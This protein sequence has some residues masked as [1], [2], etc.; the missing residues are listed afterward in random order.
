MTTTELAKLVSQMR[1]AQKTYFKTRNTFDLAIS[2][3]MEHRVDR[4]VKECLAPPTLF[5][6]VVISD[7][8]TS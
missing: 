3:D 6:D 1:A 8:C 7:Q 2:K 5:D 4:A